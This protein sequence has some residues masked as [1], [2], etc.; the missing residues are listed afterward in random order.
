MTYDYTMTFE[1]FT[2]AVACYDLVKIPV[3]GQNYFKGYRFDDNGVKV[4][5][6]ARQHVLTPNVFTF[7]ERA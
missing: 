2:D 5:L 1:N 7:S 4:P 3:A 6:F